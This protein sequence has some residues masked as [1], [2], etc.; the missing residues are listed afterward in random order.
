MTRQGGDHELPRR[1]VH[2]A[3]VEGVGVGRHGDC[4]AVNGGAVDSEVLH[5]LI[6]VC[7]GEVAHGPIEFGART[8]VRGDLHRV[9]RPRMRSC[10]RASADLRV[11]SE[12]LARE[13]RR[14]RSELHVAQLPH[15]VLATAAAG[16]PSEEGI[17]SR[18][19]ELLPDDDA[20]A[21]LRERRFGGDRLEDACDRLLHL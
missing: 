7:E 8:E 9:T 14:V 18:L 6:G 4:P 12:G 19:H 20:F 13:F 5:D 17:G 1:G 2:E 21:A 11:A 10:E 16:D 3:I 15:V